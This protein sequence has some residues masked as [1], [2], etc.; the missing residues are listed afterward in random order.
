M[1]TFIC[2]TNVLSERGEGGE[3]GRISCWICRSAGPRKTTI[4]KSH[5]SPWSFFIFFFL[6]FLFFSLPLFPFLCLS[7]RCCCRRRRKPWPH[8]KNV[9]RRID[10]ERRLSSSVFWYNCTLPSPMLGR[11]CGGG[12]KRK[13]KLVFSSDRRPSCCWWSG[14]RWTNWITGREET[15]KWPFFFFFSFLTRK[16]FSLADRESHIALAPSQIHALGIIHFALAHGRQQQQ[17][18][19]QRWRLVESQS[20]VLH[21]FGANVCGETSEAFCISFPTNT[22]LPRRS[23]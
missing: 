19:Q 8:P 22:P 18:W 11:I 16:R 23:I 13:R 9:S 5:D 2:V 7:L 4:P 17:Q 14:G 20:H 12:S 15:W 6:S 10:T 21:K 3:R 1:H